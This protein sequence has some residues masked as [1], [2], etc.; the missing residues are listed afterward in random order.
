MPR[1]DDPSKHVTIMTM[2][3][4]KLLVIAPILCLIFFRAHGVW[5]F[6]PRFINFFVIMSLPCPYLTQI[7]R[8]CRNPMLYMYLCI[9]FFFHSQLLVWSIVTLNRMQW[10]KFSNLKGHTLKNETFNSN[11]QIERKGR[12]SWYRKILKS[13][14]RSY[15]R[16]ATDL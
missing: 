9:W 5:H 3:C 6:H 15:S 4:T 13:L 14:I 12:K 11:Q 2:K 16:T 8:V 10:A 7:S 1:Q